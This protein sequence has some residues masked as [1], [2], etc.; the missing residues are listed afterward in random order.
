MHYVYV[1]FSICIFLS[2][3]ARCWSFNP[4]V[5]G[6]SWSY[7]SVDFGIIEFKYCATQ[8]DTV[9]CRETMPNSL[10]MVSMSGD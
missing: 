2:T 9:M 3:W 4:V 8:R 1:Y 6:L 10:F 5:H 7:P